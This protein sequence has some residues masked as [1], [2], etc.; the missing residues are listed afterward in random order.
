GTIAG[1]ASVKGYK[2]ASTEMP[3]GQSG[4]NTASAAVVSSGSEFVDVSL[5]KQVAPTVLDALQA[6]EVTYTLQPRR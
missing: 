1:A 4:N 6:T 3:D 5:R 2:D